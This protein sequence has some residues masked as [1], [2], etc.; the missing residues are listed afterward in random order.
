MTQGSIQQEDLTLVNICA[1]ERRALKYINQTVTD[2]KGENG[3]KT[4]IVGDF[5]TSLT[6]MDRLS[7]QIIN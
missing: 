7:R 2:I 5:N 3:S 4:I 1:P 6:L